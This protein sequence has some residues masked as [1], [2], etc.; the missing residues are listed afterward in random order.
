MSMPRALHYTAYDV[1]AM[2]DDGKR[3]EAVH[4]E[5]LVTP[6]PGGKH[7]VILGRLYRTFDR[8]LEAHGSMT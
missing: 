5:L 1:R 6:A 2:P 7:Q 8:Y 3:Y 4:G